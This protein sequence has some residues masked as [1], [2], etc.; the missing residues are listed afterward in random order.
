MRLGSRAVGLVAGFDRPVY[1]V[2]AGQLVDTFGSGVVYPFLTLYFHLA[3]GVPLSVVGLALLANNVGLACGSV[4][5]GYAADRRGRKPVMV[6][7]LGA[8]AVALTSYAFVG[9]AGGLLAVAAAAGVAGGLYGPA[10]QAWI[11]DVVSGGDRDR[12]YSLLKVARNLGFG[13]GFVAGGVLYAVAHASV[14]VVDGLT[15]GV[16]ALLVVAAVPRVHGGT[17]DV[18]LRDAVGNWRRAVTRPRALGLAG[19]NALFAVCYVQMQATVPVVAATDLGLSSAQI[20]TL[21]TLNPI[22]IVLFQLPLTAYATRW[23]RTRTLVLSA[24]CWGASFVAVWFVGLVPA[25][26]GVG[27]VGAF[28]VARTVGEIF[29]SPFVTSLAAAFAS[30]DERGG[31]LSL[32]SVAMRLGQGVGAYLGGLAFDHGL[33]G[34]LWPGLVGVA[35]VIAVGSLAL[36]R[37]VTTAEN[38]A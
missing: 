6:V 1:V 15:A 8:S 37:T 25:L 29:H 30:A 26:V 11:A 18:S 14:F 31:G 38:A 33:Q 20:G 3:V 21:W 10:G 32:L 17:P 7:S 36:E 9:D 28:L 35:V 19:L 16:V 22:V 12:A 27:L 4:L 2:A 13:A 23:R 24:G 5:G 34:L